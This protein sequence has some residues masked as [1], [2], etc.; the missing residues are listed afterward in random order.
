[1]RIGLALS[2]WESVRSGTLT[3]I[4]CAAYITPVTVMDTVIP[5]LMARQWP[6][7]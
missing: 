2:A 5:G 1:M 4:T 6:V 3:T 7:A